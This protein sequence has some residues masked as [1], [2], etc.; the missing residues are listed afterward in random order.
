M[1]T[2]A[3]PGYIRMVKAAIRLQFQKMGGVVAVIAFG[4]RRCMKLGF[5]D[6]QVTIV[7]LTAISKNFLMIDRGNNGKARRSVAGMTVI[8]GT[9][10]IRY[11]TNRRY[12]VVA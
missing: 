4:V 8:T 11:F 2:G 3:C 1:A 12:A 9:N 7:A 5:A 6:G 10:V